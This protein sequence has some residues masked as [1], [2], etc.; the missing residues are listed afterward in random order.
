[1]PGAGKAPSAPDP[2]AVAYGHH[3]EPGSRRELSDALSL[4]DALRLSQR[5]TVPSMNAW[6]WS[7]ASSS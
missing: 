1:V 3:G 7:R 6:T 4:S 2:A 5:S